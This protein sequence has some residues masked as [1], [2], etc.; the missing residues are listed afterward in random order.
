MT[1]LPKIT[2]VRIREK[3][4]VALVERPNVASRERRLGWT[5]LSSKMCGGVDDSFSTIQEV[6]TSGSAGARR[7]EFGVAAI[8]V[9]G[10]H[11]I[12]SIGIS[13]GL[14]DQLVLLGA[15]V[16]FGILP[17]KCKLMDVP[18]MGFIG[19]GVVVL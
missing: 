13:S 10:E 7:N 19:P 12:A 2:A 14:K 8:N 1:Q 18:Q 4:V 17:T 15:E 16:S 5:S 9:H 11:L 3:E 6:S